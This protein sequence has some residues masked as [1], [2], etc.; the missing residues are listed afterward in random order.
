M[1]I[2]KIALF[3]LFVSLWG[4]PSIKAQER[5]IY[6]QYHFNYYLINPAIAGAERGSHIMLTTKNNWLGLDDA[7]GTQ[8]ASFYTRLKRGDAIGLGGYLFNDKNGQFRNIGGQVTFAY[9]IP[10]SDGR[11]Q[12]IYTELDRQ[13]SFGISA[14]MVAAGYEARP[15]ITDDP[16]NVSDFLYLPNANFGVYYSS[17][18][19]FTGFS[20]TNII[21]IRSYP[22]KWSG[23]E[24]LLAPFT[25]FLFLGYA[26]QVLDRNTHLEPSCNYTMAIYKEQKKVQNT[27][28]QLDL[29]LKFS[30]IFPQGNFGYW[31]QFSYRHNLDKGIGR[32]FSVVPMG[33]IRV[34][35]FH[36]GYA[37]NWNLSKIA[38]ASNFGTHEAVISY[39]FSPSR[40][41]AR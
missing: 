30:Q 31:L 9:H 15:E 33:G 35:G 16:A 24:S 29:N 17:Y 11:G 28:Q 8:T 26:I 3:L 39:S 10:M 25:G 7:P 19:F 14:K 6:N 36:V 38:T 1:D 40:F 18:G 22:T 4:T 23:N 20:A 2:K 21:P 5:I 37:F 41:F 34:G 12:L 27:R 13:L 32:S